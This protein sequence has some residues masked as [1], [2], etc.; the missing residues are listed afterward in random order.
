MPKGKKTERKQQYIDEIKKVILEKYP[1]AEFQVKDI[2][3]WAQE[4]WIEVY[5]RDTA[6]WDVIEMLGD[7]T[8]D[9][10]IKDGIMFSIIPQPYDRRPSVEK[11]KSA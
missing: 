5:V 7:R 9:I 11:E 10:L 2:R 1:E 4:T 3:P 8:M 6:D